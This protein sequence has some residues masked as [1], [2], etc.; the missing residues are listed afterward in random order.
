MPV[1]CPLGVHW[2]GTNLK[3]TTDTK[4]TPKKYKKV[5]NNNGHPTDKKGHPVDTQW[6][7]NRHMS[8]VY[9]LGVRWASIECRAVASLKKLGGGMDQ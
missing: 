2:V 1:G 9:S 6:T 3:I 7:P 4:R 5:K 8:I